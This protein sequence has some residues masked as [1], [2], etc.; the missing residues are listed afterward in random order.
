MILSQTPARGVTADP[1]NQRTM[2]QGQQPEGGAEETHARLS[3]CSE[4]PNQG[5]RG[6]KNAACLDVPVEAW[7]ALLCSLA[8]Q[9]LSP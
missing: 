5:D 9:R 3:T 1:R 8:W 2:G 4:N 6:P 7:P